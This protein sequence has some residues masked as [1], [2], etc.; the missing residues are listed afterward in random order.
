MPKAEPRKMVILKSSMLWTWQLLRR[1]RFFTVLYCAERGCD[2]ACFRRHLNC[3]VLTLCWR[4]ISGRGWS[5]STP[6]RA[7]HGP[8][9]SLLNWSTVCSKIL[10]KVPAHCAAVLHCV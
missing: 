6:V 9:A 4:K 2:C 1:S 10:S 3:M 5:R 8:P 7:W